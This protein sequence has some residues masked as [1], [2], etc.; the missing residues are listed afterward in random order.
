MRASAAG[1]IGGQQYERTAAWVDVSDDDSY[2]VDV[3]RVVGGRE[4][5]K[6]MHSHFGQITPKGLTLQPVE[7]TAG[8]DQMRSWRKDSYT[9]AS[10]P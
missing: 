2:L 10:R 9:A 3:F 4:H 8:G 7:E 6:F 1:L 5:A